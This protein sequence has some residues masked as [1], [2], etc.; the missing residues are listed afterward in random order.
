MAI[1]PY[2]VG[3]GIKIIVVAFAVGEKWTRKRHYHCHESYISDI[4]CIKKRVRIKSLT[5]IVLVKKFENSP[6]KLVLL[7]ELH[8]TVIPRFVIMRITR[9]LN[10]SSL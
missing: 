9:S 3:F 2:S 7:Y 5:H 4:H 1:D 6:A 10:R 8:P